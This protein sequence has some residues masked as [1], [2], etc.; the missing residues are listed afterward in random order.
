MLVAVKII[1]KP[2]QAKMKMLKAEVDI[3]TKLDHPNVVRLHK[4]VDTDTKLCASRP[5]RNSAIARRCARRPQR[6]ARPDG[7]DRLMDAQ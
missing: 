1:T 6:R 4:V 7:T 5:R 3:M 2:V